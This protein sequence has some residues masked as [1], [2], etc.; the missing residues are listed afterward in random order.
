MTTRVTFDPNENFE[1]AGL[2]VYGDDA[3]YVKANI[4]HSGGRGLEFLMSSTNR[5]QV[6][7]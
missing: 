6:S 5:A 7:I 3:N 4:V 1:Q 2:L